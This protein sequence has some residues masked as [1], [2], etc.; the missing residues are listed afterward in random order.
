MRL[1]DFIHDVGPYVTYHPR[2][3][4]ITG[5]VTATIFLS[6]L[7][8]WEGSQRDP[9]GWIY[10]TRQQMTEDT[11]LT[12]TEQDTARRHLVERGLLEQK[13]KGV[14]ATMH[15]RL[16]LDA[17]NDAWD[18][19]NLSAETP[20]SSLQESRKLDGGNPANKSAAILQSISEETTDSTTEETQRSVAPTI[21]RIRERD[22]KRTARKR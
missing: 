19:A 12:R 14:P 13:L 4:R 9:D 2:L 16:D 15:Y 1:T 17:I 22:A 3:N 20:Q 5:S 10:K 11:G 7:L 18:A 21:L 6:S 8:A